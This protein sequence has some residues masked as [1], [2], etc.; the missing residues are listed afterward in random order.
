[1]EKEKLFI[2]LDDIPLSGKRVLVRVDFNVPIRNSRITDDSRIRACLP[3]INKILDA[4]ARLI[5]MSHMGRPKE[6]Q[7]D[8]AASLAPVAAQLE[9]LLGKKV[10]LLTDWSQLQDTSFDS[11][12]LMENVRFLK[13]ETSND[14]ELARKMAAVCD[15]YVND[16]FAAAHRTHASTYGVA[17]YA[18]V[19]CAG[20]LLVR[21]MEALTALFN[22]PARPLVAIVGGSKVST[23]LNILRSLLDKVDQL[24]IGGGIANTF[25]KATGVNI[26]ESLCEE[27]LL[28]T[29]REILTFAK[30]QG[31]SIPL[32]TDVVCGKTVSDYAEAIIK[33][34]NQIAVDD[35]I[36]DV[37]PETAKS[38]ATA[39]LSART[40]IWNGPLGVFEIEQFSN[41]TGVIANAIADS[42]AFSVAGGGDTLAAIAK[43]GIASKLSY[44]TTAGGAFLEYLEG[45]TMPAIAILEERTLAW[46]AT[47]REY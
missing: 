24:I 46:Q 27:D 22:N 44:I 7:F 43:F 31:K 18:P 12:V 36:L 9:Q 34:V 39:L 20:P 23:K 40:I 3:T 2:T 19:A 30:S 35:L 4:G 26:G 6:G 1:M 17:K 38:Y 5:L 41:G 25:L 15:V 13:G 28:D 8:Q 47:E 45:K 14:D 29:A 10:S 42:T 32:P 33:P 21:E 11:I 37:G 16:A